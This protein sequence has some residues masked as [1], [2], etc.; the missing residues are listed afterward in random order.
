MER[1]RCG[2]RAPPPLEVGVER[3]EHLLPVGAVAAEPAVGLAQR[4]RN[5]PADLDPPLLL[6]LDE[7]GAGEYPDVLRDGLERDVERRRKRADGC[8][9]VRERAQDRA[10]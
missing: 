8:L 3:V 2:S 9:A 5:E 7:P 4:R 1:P 6:A 10:P